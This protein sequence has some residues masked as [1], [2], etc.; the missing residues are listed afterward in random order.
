MKK[1]YLISILSFILFIIITILVITNTIKP[2]DDFIYNSLFGLRNNILDIF[3]KLITELAN[4]IPVII[5]YALLVIILTREDSILLSIG[6]FLTV[7]INQI[8]KRIFRRPRPAHL[9]LIKQGGFSYPSGHAMMALCI[10][11]TLI[12]LCATKIK[13]KK[14]RITLITLL[15]LLIILIGL[16]RIYVGVHYPSDIVGGYSLTISIIILSITNTNKYLRGKN[17]NDKDGN[18]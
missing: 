13:N 6:M 18:K 17:K 3:F 15:T 10:Y 2:F 16:S 9:R 7:G 1:R 8:L 4:P 11:G 5:I 14:L 12:Y